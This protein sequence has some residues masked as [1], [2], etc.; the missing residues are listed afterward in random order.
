MGKKGPGPR[1]VRRGP[2]KGKK[3]LGRLYQ[4][5]L[6]HAGEG[7]EQCEAIKAEM[8]AHHVETLG[9]AESNP[10]RKRKL[11]KLG[12]KLRRVAR[13]HRKVAKKLAPPHPKKVAQMR[14]RAIRAQRPKPPVHSLHQKGHVPLT[15]QQ[16]RAIQ[17]ERHTPPMPPELAGL[18][19]SSIGLDHY[20]IALQNAGSILGDAFGDSRAVKRVKRRQQRRTKALKFGVKKAKKAKRIVKHR[21]AVRKHNRTA[22]RAAI[23]SI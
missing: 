16:R 21:Q 17:A 8:A 1:R 9:Q 4:N 10:K 14:R 20:G 23:Q 7:S 22:R 2:P 11:K 12:R 15:P 18:H 13:K 3:D 6:A 5:C 19:P